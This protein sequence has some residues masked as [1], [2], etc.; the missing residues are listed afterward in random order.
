M[1]ASR[2]L[3]MY[4]SEVSGHH[5]ATISI[6]KALKSLKPEIVT[7]NING[8][9]YTNPILEKV[10]N[11]VYLSVIKRRPEVWEYLYDNPKVVKSTKHIK[12]AIHKSNHKKLQALLDEFHP[13]FIVCTQAFP[14]GMVADFKKTF[15]IDIPLMGVLTDFAPHAF[16]LYDEVDYFIVP[17]QD[18]RQRFIREGIKEDKIKIFGIPIDRKFSG[19]VNEE[20]VA[21]DLGLDKSKP[22]ILIMGGGQGIG[23]IKK[24]IKSFNKI[25]ADFQIIVVTGTNN[26]LFNWLSRHKP[27][28]KKLV[29][30]G[31]VNNID[32]LMSIATLLITKP[33]GITSA[34]ALSKN[35]PMIIMHPIP[36]Q[37]ANNTE[38]LLRQGVAV[39]VDTLEQ[40]DRKI[41]E[42]LNSKDAIQNMRR[43]AKEISFPDASMNIAKLI[44]GAN[45]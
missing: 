23:P 45:V 11:R 22:I 17:N 18:S 41:S 30:L 10:I 21:A 12:D 27:K 8:F 33:G 24:I 36:G 14:C 35:L 6:E 39:K 38:Y 4:I 15:N 28:D 29:A 1:P 32:E 44:L 43:C 37:E 9:N 16:W 2:V 13:D 19:Y 25:K 31:Y 5:S 20:R 26:R 42:L 34:E 40:L 3:L 7:K